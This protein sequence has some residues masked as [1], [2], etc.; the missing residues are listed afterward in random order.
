MTTPEPFL[1]AAVA[2]NVLHDRE[3]NLQK[4][5]DF[6]GQ[7]AAQG[8]RLVVFPEAAVQGFLFHVDTHFDPNEAQYHWQN[9]EHV[10]GPTTAQLTE[11][12]AQHDLVVV[13]GLME[14]V[15]HPSLPVLHNSAVVVGPGGLLGVYRKVHQPS[16]ETLAYRTGSQWPVV[17]TP[18]GRLGALI[19][20]DQCFPEAARELTLRGAQILA[21]PNAWARLDR[22]SDDRY[23]FFGRAR[24][25][26]NC[27]WLLQANQVGPSDRGDHV[28]LGY[29]RI[30]DPA[31]Q[32]A[33]HVVPGAE[34]LAITEI[35]ATTY[36]PT[37]ARAGWLLQQ[38]RPETYTA[39]ADAT[40]YSS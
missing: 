28:Y 21:I 16:E 31:G 5:Q 17:D 1:A 15:D 10:P 11:W 12:C 29:S 25:A 33:A 36:D 40:P 18:L 34:G 26:E 20:Y 9:A 14:R 35:T 7:A 6:M 22:A 38:R 30:I 27:R 37:R 3:Q 39:T 4:I 2:M 8:A 24:A 13:V 19:C 32:V 23:D